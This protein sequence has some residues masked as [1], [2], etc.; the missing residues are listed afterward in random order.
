M[1][2][3][4][5]LLSAL[6]FLA[7]LLGITPASAQTQG[8]QQSWPQRSVK[9]VLPVGAGA[10]ADIVAR[11]F[12]DGLAARWSQPVMVENRP[13]ADGFLAITSVIGANDDHVLLLSPASIFTAHRYVHDKLPYDPR[14]LVPIARVTNTLIVI[15]VPAALSINSL[16]EL[17]K[18]VRAQPGTLNWASMTGANALLFEGF[19]KEEKLKMMKVP[20]G[21]PV[22][23]VTDV[24]EGRVQVYVAALAIVQPHINAGKVKALALTNLTEAGIAPGIP[25]AAR[26]G[27]PSLNFDG[28]IGVLGP[29]GMPAN[30]RERI[31]ADIREVAKDAKIIDRLSKIGQVLSPGTPAEFGAAI[32]EQYGTVARI[33][34]TL[35]IKPAQ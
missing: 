24:G 3:F 12:A 23:A 1:P 20:Y 6:S 28:L 2:R 16:P 19:L 34:K 35:G 11:L 21:N 7:L 32:E 10:G 29:R 25:T 27:Y 17:V 18:Q 15:A 22:Q 4:R 9:F 33:G 30:L 8:A 13:G 5:T 14:D 26:A 31:A